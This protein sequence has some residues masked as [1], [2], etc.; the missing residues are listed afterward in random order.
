MA[1]NVLLVSTLDTKREE[2]LYLRGKLESL[3]LHAILMDLSMRG[4]LVPEA[5]ISPDLVA[6][7]G[8]KEFQEIKGSTRRDENTNCMVAGAT[9]LA[10]DL[11]RRKK[12]QGIIGVGGATGSFMATEIMRALPFGLPKLMVSSAAALP[13]LSSRYIGM[14]DMMLFHSVI[15]ISGLTDLLKNVLDRAANAMSAMTHGVVAT[16]ESGRK[17][18]IAM[19]VMGTCEKCA[20]SLRSNLE[21]A[22]YE[23]VAFSA[24]GIGD[25][26]ME[27]MI[28]DGFFQGVIDLATGGVGEHLFGFTRDAGPNRLESAGKQKIPQVISTCGVNHITPAK[29]KYREQYHQRRK[30]HLDKFRTW[31]R[32]SPEELVQ[33]ADAFAEKLNWADGPVEIVIPMKGWSSADCP[34]NPTYD[35]EEDRIFIRQLRAKLREDIPIREVDANMEDPEFA[36]AVIRSFMDIV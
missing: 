30:Y 31:L 19:T 6:R 14:S 18:A 28:S 11:F 35:P 36:D 33:M 3:G 10:D 24:A 32:A 34:G 8:G 17:R 2:T 4:D 23:V 27:K 9:K 21:Q 5:E 12:V 29:S 20:T 25:R 22:G 26:A 16:L 13:G 1:S 7:A 15:E